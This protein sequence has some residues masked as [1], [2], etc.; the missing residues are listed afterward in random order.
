MGLFDA[1]RPKSWEEEDA[2]DGDTPPCPQCGT[3]LTKKYTYSEMYCGSCHYGLE[4]DDGGD[5]D[6]TLSVHEAANIWA[7]N[8]KD[9]AHAFG[10][11]EDE[12]EKALRD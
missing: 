9:E 12:L 10:Y 7:S 6:E 8:G 2:Y 1:F 11:S 5:A 3:P 4:S